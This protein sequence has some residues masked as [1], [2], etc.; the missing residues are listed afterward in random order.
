ME[1]GASHAWS[2]SPQC[3]SPRGAAAGFHSKTWRT[4]ASVGQHAL[5]SAA[6]WEEIFLRKRARDGGKVKT[7][8]H[9]AGRLA[10]LWAQMIDSRKASRGRIA[11][12]E[13][14]DRKT[15]DELERMVREFSRRV[16][17]AAGV[18]LVANGCHRP[19]RRWRRRKHVSEPEQLPP[20][21]KPGKETD[22]VFIRAAKGDESVYPQVRAMLEAGDGGAN[23]LI[24]GI[25]SIANIARIRFINKICGKDILHKECVNAKLE[26]IRTALTDGEDNLTFLDFLMAE[27]ITVLWLDVYY[28]QLQAQFAAGELTPTLEWRQRRLTQA[29]NRF[30]RAC[31]AYARIRR[32]SKPRLVAT[33]NVAANAAQVN[34]GGPQ[35]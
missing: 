13:R 8:Y 33:V 20:L 24:H 29:S 19:G 1:P 27:R 34:V 32:L 26:F 4:R 9:G 35:P 31:V 17:Q 22:D 2:Q 6:K 28:A 3:G 21:P 10:E 18:L 30:D 11:A 23:A 7:H 16:D 14:K 25:G 5:E 15:C 12:A